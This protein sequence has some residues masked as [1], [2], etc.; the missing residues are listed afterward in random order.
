VEEGRIVYDNIIN[1]TKFLVSI[2]V[3]EIFLIA[4]SIIVG[5]NSPLTAIQILWMNLIT[6]SFPALALGMENKALDIMTRPPRKKDEK[7]LSKPR[8][9]SMIAVGL[10]MAI[11]TIIP[12]YY[13]LGTETPAIAQT[14]AFN[15]IIG[16]QLF[17]AFAS[18]SAKHSIFKLGLLT[19]KPLVGAVILGFVLQIAIVH[20]QAFQAIFNTVPLNLA[21]W[22]IVA[23]ASLSLLVA[24]EAAK[25]FRKS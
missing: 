3:G 21:Q 12:Y 6:G 9:T 5:L 19:N 18:R 1:T 17:Y 8:L 15:I 23:I 20:I 11:T 4:G 13:L 24:S 16:Q 25:L 22:T 2:G 10:F 7:I 14:V